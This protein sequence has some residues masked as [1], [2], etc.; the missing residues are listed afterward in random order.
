MDASKL[1]RSV[2]NPLV[3]GRVYPLKVPE[4]AAET[5][6]GKPYIVYT[7][8]TSIDVTTNEGHT[9]HERVPIQIDV[10]AP[11]YGEADDT[12]KLALKKISDEIEGAAFGGRGPFPDPDLYRQTAD[13]RI[14]GTIF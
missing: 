5:V 13:I 8:I 9:G 11:T 7:P 1:I 6:K 10:Y 12:M 4:A 3:D 2:L 14:W